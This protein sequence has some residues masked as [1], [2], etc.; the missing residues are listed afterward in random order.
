MA[1]EPV[2]TAPLA[3]IK[4]RGRAIGK[5]R[6]I[7]VN[8]N[9]RLGRVGGIGQLHPDELPVLEWNGSVS[10]DF[11]NIDFRKSQVPGVTNR[12]AN[13]IE[14]W[15]DNLMLTTEGVD[16]D[17]YRKVDSGRQ[18]ASGLKIGDLSLYATVR[19]LILESE[20]FDLNEGQVSGRKQS[21]Q[22]LKP[23][24]YKV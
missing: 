8:E 3:I 12:V 18:T 10:C 1:Y 13:T 4:C 22:Y 14:E 16:L 11:Y 6:G 9:H 2:I 24:L 20:G 19:G 23:I 7:N 15:A 21:F 5:M 17:I